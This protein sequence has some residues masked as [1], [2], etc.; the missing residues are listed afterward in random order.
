MNHYDILKSDMQ[1]G[2]LHIT[3]IS[4][5]VNDG[6]DVQF[7]CTKTSNGYWLPDVKYLQKKE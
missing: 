5:I 1:N 4:V 2:I 6:N 7:E 3:G